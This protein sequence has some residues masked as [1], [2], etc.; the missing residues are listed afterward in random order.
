MPE[1]TS[2]GG[3]AIM[4]VDDEVVVGLNIKNLLEQHGYR[5]VVA[6]SGDECLRQ[7]ARGD[8]PDLILMDINLGPNRMDG[9]ETTRRVQELADIPVVL[10][11]AYTDRA[12]IQGTRNMTK[13][14]YVHKVPGN[15]EFILATVEMA[16]KLQE[17]EQMYRDL[18]AHINHTREEQNAFM[19]REIHDDLGQ[20][21]AALKI[22]LTMLERSTTP[23]ETPPIIADMREILDATA[24]KI[25]TLIRELRPPVT[26]TAD[27]IEALKW[28]VRE[29]E[30]TFSIPTQFSSAVEQAVLG[31][32]KSLSVFRIVQE[33]LTNAVRHGNPSAISVDVGQE[34][35]SLFVRIADDGC[36]FTPAAR[37]PE[38]TFGILGMQERAERWRGS[39][40]IESKPGEGT[41]VTATVPHGLRPPELSA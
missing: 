7:I 20:S 31:P 32:E 5:A 9:Q 18:S 23:A 15:E 27:I 34:D 1:N 14:G 12:T 41:I 3:K 17:R 16:F 39:V 28:H 8:V 25:R 36:G 26:D 10:H 38:M 2:A 24:L 11:S 40:S 4:I 22:N 33:A 21:I 13:Y 35:E 19:A 6:S 37:A 30:K 29:F